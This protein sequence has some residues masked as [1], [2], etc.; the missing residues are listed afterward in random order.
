MPPSGHS[1][2]CR[3]CR[4]CSHLL[5]PAFLLFSAAWSSATTAPLS[6]ED[7][8][9]SFDSTPVLALTRAL[10]PPLAAAG[11]FST[12]FERATA[13][14]GDGSRTI[15]AA[16]G[17]PPDDAEGERPLCSTCAAGHEYNG[18][19]K[20]MRFL[21][22]CGTSGGG[23]T[24][25]AGACTGAQSSGAGKLCFR[26]HGS[27]LMLAALLSKERSHGACLFSSPSCSLSPP[28]SLSSSAAQSA[29]HTLFGFLYSPCASGARRPMA[30]SARPGMS[31]S[32]A[33][34]SRRFVLWCCGLSSPKVYSTRRNSME[35]Q[36]RAKTQRGARN[37]RREE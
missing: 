7:C 23:G 35:N 34:K 36:E 27:A 4:P 28:C 18:S 1:R 6:C 26:V 3:F 11:L 5:C 21:D 37:E 19:R 25:A 8:C 14:S 17:I 20:V 9:I 16:R 10:F 2:Q 31:T 29:A 12:S 24:C 33:V 30:S 13:A 22:R 15:S 32:E